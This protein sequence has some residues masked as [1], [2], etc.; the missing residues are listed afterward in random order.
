MRRASP[1]A[2]TLPRRRWRRAL[3]LILACATTSCASL[4]SPDSSPAAGTT[5]ATAPD[6]DAI[7]YRVV[8]DAPR[9]VV[10]LLRQSVGLVRWQAYADMTDDLLDRLAREAAAESRDAVSTVGYFSPDVDVAVDRASKPITV[11]LH[12]ALGEPTRIR[13]VNID[14]TGPA[15]NDS[16]EGA[17][18]IA[19]LRRDWGLPQGTIFDQTTWDRAK[20]RA[21][22]T[23]AASPY[24][25]AAL[26]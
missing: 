21:V 12:V 25:A 1:R 23:L 15:V 10:E 9:N 6:P 17:A 11:T 22:Q 2:S 18:A 7:H 24:A 19:K 16:V 3:T 5:P 26:T 20:L 8:I 13:E 4:K 14:V